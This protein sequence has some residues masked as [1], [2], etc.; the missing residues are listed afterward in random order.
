MSEYLYLSRTNPTS[1]TPFYFLN[2]ASR[3]S[4]GFTLHQSSI[5]ISEESYI[6]IKGLKEER[7][8]GESNTYYVMI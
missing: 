7:Y 1:G 8:N 5:M 4:F 3:D 6:R 2:M